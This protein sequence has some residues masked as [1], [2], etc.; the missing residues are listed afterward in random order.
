MQGVWIFLGERRGIGVVAE[1]AEGIIDV[2]R[3]N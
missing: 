3:S 2:S 1:S